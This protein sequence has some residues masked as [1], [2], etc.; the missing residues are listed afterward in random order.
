[1]TERL[2]VS[3]QWLS[4]QSVFTFFILLML[5]FFFAVAL[6][7]CITYGR[8]RPGKLASTST[9]QWTPRAL[10]VQIQPQ[11]CITT[12][13]PWNYVQIQ[14]PV[15][16]ISKHQRINKT[17]MCQLHKLTK[18]AKLAQYSTTNK[19]KEFQDHCLDEFQLF[20]LLL[21][22]VRASSFCTSLSLSADC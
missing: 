12:F 14:R 18:R 21:R 17:K 15:L 22:D 7:L 19:I 16:F 9:K 2:R 13:S 6:F 8:H 20:S 11:I 4:L 1:M 10:R 3:Y 5:M